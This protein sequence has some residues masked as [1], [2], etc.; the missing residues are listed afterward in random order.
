M[1]GDPP[2]FSKHT[3][4]DEGSVTF[5]DNN[6]GKIIGK[7]TIGNKSN[8]LIEDV[9]LV[10]GLK[11]NLLSISQLCDKGYIVRFETNACIIEKLYKN[12]S[13]IVLK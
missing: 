10:E 11:Y 3:S 2:Q 4:L 8:L 9:L 13:M 1:I 5:G 6:K 7:W 12:T